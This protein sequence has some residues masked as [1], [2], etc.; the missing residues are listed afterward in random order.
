MGLVRL[1]AVLEDHARDG[2]PREA[3]VQRSAPSF[4]AERMEVVRVHGRQQ[5][6][7]PAPA[8]MMCV[9]SP[10]SEFAHLVNPACR[11]APVVFTPALDVEQW[12]GDGIGG[13]AKEG[14]LA[15]PLF[16]GTVSQP[17][18]KQPRKGKAGAK[19][20]GNPLFGGPDRPAAPAP[21]GVAPFTPATAAGGEPFDMT[22]WSAGLSQSSQ[23]KIVSEGLGCGDTASPDVTGPPTPMRADGTSA[24]W[25]VTIVPPADASY[26]V[27]VCAVNCASGLGYAAAGTLH[28]KAVA[29]AAQ[30]CEVWGYRVDGFRML[31]PSQ[32]GS[33]VIYRCRFDPNMPGA[34]KVSP[35]CSHEPVS[36]FPEGIDMVHWGSPSSCALPGQNLAHPISAR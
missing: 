28:A 19:E 2:F 30:P 14:T 34:E 10:E 36:F 20:P 32:Y 27:C 5:P 9:F 26:T 13:C 15:E 21:R 22:V 33:A 35:H 31:P 17:A 24:T 25:K 23:L 11:T 3:F 1:H 8:P 12:A 18:E 29:K 16:K 7:P 6:P 4:L